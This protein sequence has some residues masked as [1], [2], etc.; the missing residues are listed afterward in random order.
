VKNLNGFG[1]IRFLN[2]LPHVVG[3][4]VESPSKPEQKPEHGG[5]TE[6]NTISVGL[7]WG[8]GVLG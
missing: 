3:N 6:G 1:V 5:E 8:F 2:R 4:W 7:A